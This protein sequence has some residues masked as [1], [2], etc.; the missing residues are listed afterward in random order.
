MSA[1][2]PMATAVTA[3]LNVARVGRNTLY[4]VAAQA[5]SAVINVT[6]MMLL[7][8][9]LSAAGYG[10]YVFWYALVPLFASVADLGAGVIVTGAIA[11][12]PHDTRRL[13]GDALLVRAAVAVVVLLVIA[14][15]VWPVL[16][17]AR[18][19][20]LLCVAAAALM[21]FSQD[22]AVWASRARE[23]LDVEAVFLLVS[24]LAWLAGIA[25]A[26]HAGAG[27][28]VLIGTAAAA[29][30]LRMLAGGLWLARTGLLPRFVLDRTR[31]VAL[32]IEGWPVA[33][34]LFLVVLYGRAGVFALQAWSSASE[35]ACFNVAY[36]LAQPLGF[37]A[38]ALAMSVFPSVARIA[39]TDTAGLQRMLRA[40]NKFQYIVA[41][42]LAAGLSITAA[43]VVPLFFP[44]GAG[45][46]RAA[47]GL[48]VIA[49][50]LPFVFM[51]LQSRYLLA[52]LGRQR[53]Y[54]IAVAIGLAVN[55]A[56]C[57]LFVRSHGAVGAAWTFVVAEAVVFGICQFAARAYFGDTGAATEA[58]RPFAAAAVM[59][60]VAVSLG[61][62]PL[63]LAIAVG[64]VTYAAALVLTGAWGAS[65]SQSL[66]R[67]FTSFRAVRAPHASARREPS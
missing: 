13:L 21:D 4:R 66:Y 54:L 22:A 43:R 5:V 67:V 31:L 23:R 25:V 16:G 7:G 12:A 24:Q 45:F 53:T 29:F 40:A 15:A 59:A 1:M 8:G 52:A 35:V 26:L 51:N 30:A 65:E 58:A 44:A 14:A 28:P 32:V 18:G 62:V 36:L 57:A 33:M 63:A 34:S 41:C 38:S 9:Q 11:R 37:V 47:A 17:A 27:L 39:D 10:E 60:A 61:P 50:S 2:A 64:A 42:P 49:L 19:L 20:L 6:G 48:A 3:P 55:V 46:E 56:G